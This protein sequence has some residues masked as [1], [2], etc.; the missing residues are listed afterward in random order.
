VSFFL[1]E[2]KDESFIGLYIGVNRKCTMRS[3]A[4]W[5]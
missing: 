5:I 2:A 3:C 4:H 1:K